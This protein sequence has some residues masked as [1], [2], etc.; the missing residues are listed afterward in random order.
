MKDVD[1]TKIKNVVVVEIDKFNELI[2]QGY[3]LL[4]VCS[5]TETTTSGAHE[6]QI[7]YVMGHE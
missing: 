7:F 6:L 4:H 3:I 2:K 1:I 5:Q